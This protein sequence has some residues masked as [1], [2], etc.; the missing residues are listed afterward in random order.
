MK[1]VGKFYC[2]CGQDKFS[3]LEEQTGL[4]VITVL[5]CI[6]CSVSHDIEKLDTLK[7][8]EI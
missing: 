4:Q 8:E 7:Y 3:F 1:T 5:K 2:S 6:S